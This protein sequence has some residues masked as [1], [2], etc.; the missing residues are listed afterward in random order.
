M[1]LQTLISN[2]AKR[3]ILEREKLKLER[4]IAQLVRNQQ[5][6]DELKNVALRYVGPAKRS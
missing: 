4:E 1:T 6:I 3:I 5:I 2:L